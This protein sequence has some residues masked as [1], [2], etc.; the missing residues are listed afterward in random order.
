MQ[1][2]R[3]ARDFV[4]KNRK[5]ERA[6][7]TAFHRADAGR[8]ALEGMESYCAKHPNSPSPHRVVRH[9][10]SAVDFGSHCLA[11]ALKSESLALAPWW[12]ERFAPSTYNTGD[13][14]SPS[15]FFTRMI[16][17]IYLSALLAVIWLDHVQTN[18]QGGLQENAI[19]AHDDHRD[20]TIKERLASV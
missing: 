11:L 15:E 13:G 12:K 16:A 18:R 9:C 17:P 3:F 1:R 6:D 8:M 5:E 10:R 14:V 2:T 7:E 19:F 20:Q 4:F